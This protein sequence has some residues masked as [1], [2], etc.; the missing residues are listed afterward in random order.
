[1][2]TNKPVRFCGLPDPSNG[3]FKLALAQQLFTPEQFKWADVQGVGGVMGQVVGGQ[4]EVGVV[5][6]EEAVA[7]FL[8]KGDVKVVGTYVSSPSAWTVHVAPES[9]YWTMEDLSQLTFGVSSWGSEILSKKVVQQQQ[10]G[11]LKGRGVEGL[12]QA[13]DALTHGRI[14]TFLWDSRTSRHLLDQGLT[15]SLGTVM[16][17]WPTSVF[18]MSS[19]DSTNPDLLD[20]VQGVLDIVLMVCEEYRTNV[21]D[22]T[23]KYLGGEYGMAE[24]EARAWLEGLTF[25]CDMSVDVDT[26]PPVGPGVEQAASKASL[27]TY[28]REQKAEVLRAWREA[29]LA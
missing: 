1:M 18:V 9:P 23:T 28:S 20:K 22:E 2:S 27:K 14:D 6:S 19:P 15:R 4:C 17:D 24:G 26:L 10:G 29:R 13:L 16:P 21:E 11:Q 8:T 25:Q 7:R 12:D 3:P 5:P